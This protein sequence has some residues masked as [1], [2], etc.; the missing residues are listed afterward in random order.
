MKKVLRILLIILGVIA[1]YMAGTFIYS[2][3][4]TSKASNVMLSKK[5]KANLSK[6]KA[7]IIYFS[8][9]GNTQIAAD[10]I[11]QYTNADIVRLEPQTPYPKDYDDYVPVA[12]KQLKT[13][14]YPA[15]KDNLPNLNQYSVIYVGFPTW[16]HQ[17]PRIIHTLF[18]DYDFKNK[19]IVPFTTSMSD[20]ISKSMPYIKKMAQKDHAKVINGFRY[21]DNNQELKDY[22]KKNKLIK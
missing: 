18:R 17:P 1:L 14:A 21:D 20:P 2:N 15:I 11:K 10:Q 3:H 12:R 16:W 5:D 7:L 4:F 6:Q 9:S 8:L 22:L 19:V 13:K